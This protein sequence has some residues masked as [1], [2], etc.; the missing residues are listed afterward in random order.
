MMEDI[1]AKRAKR[2]K[3]G[4]LLTLILL[5]YGLA[6][7][8]A[9]FFC[10]PPEWFVWLAPFNVPSIA[11]AYWFSPV[12]LYL[13][14]ALAALAGWMVLH[15]G[16]LFGREF[17]IVT[18]LIYLICNCVFVPFYMLLVSASWDVTLLGRM[19]ALSVSGLVY[20]ILVLVALHV[21]NP[22]RI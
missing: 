20:P 8:V 7:T 6:V 12:L 11:F 3:L 19:L 2:V 10:Q 14:L 21:W 4:K 18:M 5:L 17:I 16:R 1:Q 15:L 9:Y 22:R 13:P